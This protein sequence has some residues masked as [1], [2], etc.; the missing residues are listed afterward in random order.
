MC[1]GESFAFRERDGIK[2][3]T[4][5]SSSLNLHLFVFI[6]NLKLK[7]NSHYFKINKKKITQQ[8][9]KTPKL[10][11]G[12]YSEEQ[13]LKEILCRGRSCP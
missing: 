5:S 2:F 1:L 6:H 13:L 11:S 9:F 7:A 12:T 10:K 3:L 4:F 8:E